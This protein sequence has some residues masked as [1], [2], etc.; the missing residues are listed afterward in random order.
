MSGVRINVE[1]RGKPVADGVEVIKSRRE[2]GEDVERI[3]SEY[4]KATPIDTL[5][6]GFGLAT[7]TVVKVTGCHDCPLALH[8][9]QYVIKCEHPESAQ[10]ARSIPDGVRPDWCPGNAGKLVIEWAKR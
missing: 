7:P 6:D 3:V 2:M 5:P 10:P 9:S 4:R 8:V 1:I